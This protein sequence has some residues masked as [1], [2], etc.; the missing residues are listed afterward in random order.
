ML[1]RFRRWRRERRIRALMPQAPVPLESALAICGFNEF[2]DA[3]AERDLRIVI[4]IWTLLQYYW[5]EA[6][7]DY[8]NP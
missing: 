1:T 4:S 2:K 8:E 7:V 5:A 3:G 6:I